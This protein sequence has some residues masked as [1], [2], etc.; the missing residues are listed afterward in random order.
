MGKYRNINH[1][2][3]TLGLSAALLFGVHTGA[4]AAECKEM[5]KAACEQNAAQ[6]SWVE[7]YTRKDG[8][9]VSGHCRKKPGKKAG[10]S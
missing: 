7:P 2:L 6:C 1:R 4:A 3:G 5:E 9:K 10:N 8:V